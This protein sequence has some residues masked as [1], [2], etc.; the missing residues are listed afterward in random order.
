MSAIVEAELVSSPML[1]PRT[2][3]L[4]PL[5]LKQQSF[6][7]HYLNPANYRNGTKAARLA[8]YEG[9]DNTLGAVASENLRKPAIQAHLQ[10]ALKQRHISSDEVIAE[11]SDIAIAPWKDFV[12]VKYGPNNSILD[13][14]L[15]L[16][17]KI[18]ALE[19]AG[20]YHQLW[21]KPNG[22]TNVQVNVNSDSLTVILQTVLSELNPTE[23]DT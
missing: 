2:Q 3:D 12:Q 8:G 16:S 14:Q 9:D 6:V 21:D 7:T 22:Q 13:V 15:K 18:K 11:L 19:L 20:K 10:H 5:T 1:V 23:L 17:E 4:P